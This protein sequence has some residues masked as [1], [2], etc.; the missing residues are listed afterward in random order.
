M[1]STL[2]RG[3]LGA[4]I[5]MNSLAGDPETGKTIEAYM[6]FILDCTPGLTMIPGTAEIRYSIEA[7]LTTPSTPPLVPCLTLVRRLCHATGP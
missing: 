1:V 4:F 7:R 2:S 5:Y 6:Q 3:R